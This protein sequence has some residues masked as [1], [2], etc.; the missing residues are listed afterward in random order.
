MKT[1]LQVE[2]AIFGFR[3][4]EGPHLKSEPV[5]SEAFALLSAV[6]QA[7]VGGTSRL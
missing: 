7:K 6:G 1:N 3:K 2:N 5:Q 4:P